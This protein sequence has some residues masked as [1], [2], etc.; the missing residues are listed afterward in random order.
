[1]HRRPLCPIMQP[2]TAALLPLNTGS[3]SLD[4][5]LYHVE[6]GQGHARLRGNAEGISGE[7]WLRRVHGEAGQA[8]DFAPVARQAEAQHALLA[9]LEPEPSDTALLGWGSAGP[10]RQPPH[11]ANTGGGRHTR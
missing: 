4:F 11:R 1:M 9:W 2:M 6:A 3:S 7:S 5:G 8:G 10:W